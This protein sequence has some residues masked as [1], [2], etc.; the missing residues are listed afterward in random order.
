MSLQDRINRAPTWL[1]KLLNLPVAARA[2]DSSDSSAATPRQPTAAT[3][4]PYLQI[5][6][7]STPGTVSPAPSTRWSAEP[8]A[9]TWRADAPTRRASAWLLALR[10]LVAAALI[11]A[12]LIAVP[13]VIRTYRPATATS[14]G[15]AVKLPASAT[16]PQAAAGG[17]ASRFAAAYLT[18]DGASPEKR[19]R[20]L[21]DAGWTGAPEIG[22]DGKG[23]QQLTGTVTVARVDA[24]SADRGAATVVATVV[25]FLLRGDKLVGAAPNTVALRVPMTVTPDGRVQPAAPP[26]LVAPPRNTSPAGVALAETD[27]RLTS[28]T[29]QAAQD[30]F[31]AY[32]SSADLTAIAAPGATITGLS[33]D[34]TLVRITDW[35]V[36]PPLKDQTAAVAAVM[37]RTQDG[38]QLEQT[39]R[40]TLRLT[41]SGPTGRW[42]VLT[43]L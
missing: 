41:T 14:S 4:N 32:G 27:S 36:A 24:E 20:A 13:A 16:F 12:V 28:E 10:G 23:R 39:Y 35:D 3:D 21:A 43:I 8:A 22:W 6:Q 37:W 25:P 17:V 19:Q 2:H 11:L 29:K 5:A 33:G 34:V 38:A 15:R 7:R 42:Q 30:F 1:V 31:A 26:S 9:S 40:L 18:W